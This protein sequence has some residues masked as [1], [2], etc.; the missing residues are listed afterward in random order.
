M[1]DRSVFDLSFTSRLEGEI[2]PETSRNLAIE[3]AGKS[4]STV[5]ISVTDD[6]HGTRQVTVSSKVVA[7]FISDLLLLSLSQVANA[8]YQAASE[9]GN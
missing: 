6:K 5:T 4:D 8:S 1:A 9:F 2:W 7:A 3:F